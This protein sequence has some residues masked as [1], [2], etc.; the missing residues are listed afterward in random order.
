MTC[1]QRGGAIECGAGKRRR[2]PVRLSVA[3]PDEASYRPAT[4]G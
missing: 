3:Q 2:A 1:R 4:A